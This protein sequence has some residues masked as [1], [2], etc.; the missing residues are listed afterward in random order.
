[1][2]RET[3]SLDHEIE[4]QACL[5][6]ADNLVALGRPREADE[7]YAFVLGI[8]QNDVEADLWVKWRYRQHLAASLGALRLADG[9]PEGALSL[10]R[11]CIEWATDSDSPKNFVKGLRL[12]GDALSRLG[13]DAEAADALEA[14]LSRAEHLG[15]PTQLWRCL[16]SL[17]RHRDALDVIDSVASELAV[18]RRDRMLASA[19]V[20][21]L[22]ELCA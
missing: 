16:S 15:N 2:A 8:V 14:A 9:D 20:A 11:E 1:M 4:C 17:G 6:V 7:H 12:Q 21:A 3:P 22:R 10:A 5:N 13:R 19:E 18:E